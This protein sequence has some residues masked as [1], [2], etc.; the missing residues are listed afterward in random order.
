MTVVNAGA[1]HCRKRCIGI[2]W[3]GRRLYPGEFEVGYHAHAGGDKPLHLPEGP[4]QYF[5]VGRQRHDASLI[6]ADA[7]ADMAADAG[8]SSPLNGYVALNKGCER[9]PR[10]QEPVPV[11]PLAKLQG[12]FP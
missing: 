3:P 7:A 4:V 2:G 8:K 5:S 9:F 10:R 1:Q 12:F 11:D 6:G